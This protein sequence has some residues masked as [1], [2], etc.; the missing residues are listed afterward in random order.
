MQAWGNSSQWD[1]WP[2]FRFGVSAE[3]HVLCSAHLQTTGKCHSEALFF[4]FS[5]ST[6]V[7][8]HDLT[9]WQMLLFINATESET[10]TRPLG[11]STW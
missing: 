5:S 1:S 7:L 10:C 4:G 6:A 11:S 8:T 2:T 9:L 3:M